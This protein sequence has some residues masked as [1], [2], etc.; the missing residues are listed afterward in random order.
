MGTDQADKEALEQITSI[1]RMVE[2]GRSTPLIGGEAYVLWGLLIAG[3]LILLALGVGRLPDWLLLASWFAFPI[4][5]GAGMF[6]LLQRY[7]GDGHAPSY[8]NMAVSRLWAMI[9]LSLL[10]LTTVEFATGFQSP[11]FLLI[12]SS[13]LFAVGIGTTGSFVSSRPL[14]FAAIGWV[15]VA[16]AVKFTADVGQAM[17]LVALAALLLLVAP[18]LMLMRQRKTER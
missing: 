5:A 13:L 2:R 15:G 8:R 3:F 16:A 11:V 9:A 12:A 4:V 18:G 17:L 14:L 1:R 10:A 6:V 7:A